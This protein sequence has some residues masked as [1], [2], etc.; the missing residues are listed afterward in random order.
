[1]PHPEP[2]VDAGA[3][4]SLPRIRRELRRIERRAEARVTEHDRLRRPVQAPGELLLERSD[5]NVTKRNAPPPRPALR[6]RDL[7]SDERLSDVELPV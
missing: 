3:I 7:V 6:R 5:C 4:E 2:P 1:M